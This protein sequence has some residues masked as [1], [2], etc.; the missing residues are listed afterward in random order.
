MEPGRPTFLSHKLQ[1]LKVG[2]IFTFG[3]ILVGHATAMCSP[4]RSLADDRMPTIG[5]R[6]AATTPLATGQ[7]GIIPA[8][9]PATIS[10]DKALSLSLSWG[11]KKENGQLKPVNGQGQRSGG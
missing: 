8:V 3:G 4:S 7:T 10:S 1:Y 6:A 9:I 11:Q 2:S 5:A